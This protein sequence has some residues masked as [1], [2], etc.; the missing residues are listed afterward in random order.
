MKG[1]LAALAMLVTGSC[2]LLFRK[3]TPEN[4]SAFEL[5]LHALS[6]KRR[7]TFCFLWLPGVVP[8]LYFSLPTHDV[9][10]WSV[11]ALVY[12][13]LPTFCVLTSDVNIGKMR[14][15]KLR[16]DEHEK[17][18]TD[19]EYAKN[20]YK[21]E[22]DRIKQL[23]SCGQVILA[24]KSDIITCSN[25]HDYRVGDFVIETTSY[26]KLGCPLCKSSLGYLKRDTEFVFC[27]E[28]NGL[29]FETHGL[30]DEVGL[31]QHR[32]WMHF[33]KLDASNCPLCNRQ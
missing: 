27:G 4:C 5:Q 3:T 33:F 12:L 7:R 22:S 10:W 31:T 28:P 8:S 9:M 32:A 29:Y 17:E 13:S 20:R 23:I 15:E 24:S 30:F 26:E 2:A 1:E 21:N 16:N 14:T 11:L 6:V 18:I 19:R 25:G